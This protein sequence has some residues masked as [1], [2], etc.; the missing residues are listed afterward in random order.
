MT[1]RKTTEEFKNEVYELVGDEYTVIGEYVNNKTKI[2]MRHNKCGN[3]WEI[4][5]YHFTSG[6]RRC[7][8][9]SAK[10]VGNKRRKTTEEF[11]K[12]VYELE[13]NKYTV[14]GEYI[15]SNIKI[16]MRNNESEVEFEIRPNDFL[17]GYREPNPKR[18][19][20]TK[21]FINRINELTEKN[22]YKL[23]T[24]YKDTFTKVKIKHNKCGKI[25]SMRPNDF[26]NGE[27]CPY[28]AKAK[29][30]SN[31][32]KTQEQFEKEVFELYNGEYS[33]A[34]RYINNGT[35]IKMRHNKCGKEYEVLP[36]SFLE[37]Y[38][39]CPYCNKTINGITTDVFKDRVK[40]L[41]GDEYTVL[42]EY[43]DI[44]HKIKMRH[45]KC[46]HEYEVR[47]YHF[48]GNGR[49]CPYC[50][51][52]KRKEFA[53][54][55]RK[56]QEQFEKEVF[57]LVGDEYTV[58]SE[59]KNTG[60]KIKM[61]HNK[62]SY[63][64]TVTPSSFL[65]GDRCPNC[66]KNKKLNTKTFSKRINKLFD[67]EYEILDD[68][69]NQ[70][71]KIKVKHKPCNRIFYKLPKDM[72]Q[73][74]GCP[75]CNSSS[76]ITERNIIKK[77]KNKYPS[78]KIITNSRKIIPP[79]ELDIYFPELKLAIEYNGLYWHSNIHH[80]SKY[81]INK[82]N[83]CFNKNIHLIQVFEDEIYNNEKLLYDIANRFLDNRKISSI[84][85]FEI[86]SI[87][88]KTKIKFIKENSY[89]VAHKCNKSLGLYKN[90]KL[91]SVIGYDLSRNEIIIK[92]YVSLINKPYNFL[93]QFLYHIL[94]CHEISSVYIKVD[95]RFNLYLDEIK[96]CGFMFNDYTKPH[97][98]YF[99]NNHSIT[100]KYRDKSKV[101]N[102]NGL[103]Y[104]W[105]CGYDIY[106]LKV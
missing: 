19:T 27:R 61:R 104:T 23:L 26:L 12:E 17:N 59:Y 66:R 4:M 65:N 60:T 24:E 50:A 71:T 37:G 57:D 39:K 31:K 20:N 84:K 95:K 91:L 40:K 98:F 93:N 44:N 52:L 41:V 33:V 75:Y 13:G 16:K 54:S 6:G 38:S 2:K 105:D 86:K 11:K 45:N 101:K 94:K 36:V 1:R 55:R 72:L 8:I 69:V 63:E 68:Y 82:Y 100:T 92:D 22:E 42:G 28:C 73:G 46:G 3:E 96:L 90:N 35:K 81:H 9:C 88:N 62:C 85:D 7:P 106:K 56:T 97:R 74:Y 5:P 43:I 14:L 18:V 99:N 47:P 77:L 21:T 34:G 78:L 25:F 48:T 102:K 80:N 53:K 76:S 30:S 70:D 58:L 10:K 51:K 103:L 32:R 49:R 89:F 64:Y 83:E 67:N 87:E 15:K 29:I 79:Y